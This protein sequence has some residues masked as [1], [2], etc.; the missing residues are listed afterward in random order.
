M[1]VGDTMTIEQLKNYQDKSA[2]LKLSDGE[3]ATVKVLFVDFEYEDI[4]VDIINTDRPQRYKQSDAAYTIDV[5]DIVSVEE[6]T[7]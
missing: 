7:I 2:I 1:S 4:I 5:A 6:T 3:I